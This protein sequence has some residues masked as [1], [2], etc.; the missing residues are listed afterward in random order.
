M[1]STLLSSRPISVSDDIFI[2]P[3]GPQNDIVIESPMF[4]PDVTSGGFLLDFCLYR[5][6]IKLYF[7]HFLPLMA[8]V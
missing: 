3:Q 1:S 7:H 5:H 2:V 6:K 8:V 4:I